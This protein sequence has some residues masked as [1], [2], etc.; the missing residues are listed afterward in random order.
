M[1]LST[2]A[3]L[4]AAVADWLERSDLSP[5]CADFVALAE[6]RLNR[7]L[8][9]RALER[10]VVIRVEAGA[11][12][13]RLGLPADF[14]EALGL[15]RDGPAGRQALRY[16][17]PARLPVTPLPGV[18][19]FWCLDATGLRFERPVDAASCYAL[20]MLG[21]LA[22]SDQAPTN[23]VLTDY[24]DLYLFGALVEA[25]PYLRD[26]DLLSL[27]AARFEAALGE[28]L[29]KEGRGKALARLTVEPGLTRGG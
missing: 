15:W 19:R 10:E 12:A 11:R 23:P 29:V 6:S 3:E 28:A 22:L 5:R 7:V 9:P 1:G 24:P 21:R 26:A 18:P 2:Y 27:Y 16:V 20:H 4:C 13:S 17:D 14:R 8:R 25:A